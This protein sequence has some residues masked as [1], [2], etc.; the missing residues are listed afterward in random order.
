MIIRILTIAVYQDIIA[1]LS[2]RA[3]E[4]RLTIFTAEEFTPGIWRTV[5]DGNILKE[6]RKILMTPGWRAGRILGGGRLDISHMSRDG[7]FLDNFYSDSVSNEHCLV[8]RSMKI[9]LLGSHPN[10]DN[11]L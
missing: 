1:L 8:R 6:R 11:G 4:P 5:T 10:E 2:F 3:Y 7:L 9:R